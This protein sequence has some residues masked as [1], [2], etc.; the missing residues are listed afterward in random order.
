MNYIIFKCSLANF[1]QFI[2]LEWRERENEEENYIAGND[3]NIVMAL[4]ECVFLNLFEVQGIRAQLV[5][6]EH[7]V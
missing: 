6:L 7:L 3:P 5:L 4:R 1:P 2:M